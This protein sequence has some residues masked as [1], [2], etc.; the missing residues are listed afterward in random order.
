PCG[1]LVKLN[2][3]HSGPPLTV[4]ALAPE[5]NPPNHPL[6]RT[7]TAARRAAVCRPLSFCS[8]G[9]LVPPLMYVSQQSLRPPAQVRSVFRTLS[10]F[11]WAI[12]LLHGR[13]ASCGGA[14]SGSPDGSGGSS[15]SW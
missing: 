8:L 5:M 13:L 11:T 1:R 2:P 14:W 6:Q 4:A 3:Y 15:L 7:G 12:S 10:G 9:G